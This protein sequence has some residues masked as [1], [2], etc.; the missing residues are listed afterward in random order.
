MRF[1]TLRK[2]RLSDPQIWT[3]EVTNLMANPITKPSLPL[4]T[5]SRKPQAKSCVKKL[6]NNGTKLILLANSKEWEPLVAVT[7]PDSRAKLLTSVTPIS[8]SLSKKWLP[9][10]LLTRSLWPLA[11]EFWANL[12]LE[13]PMMGKQSIFA[14][15][16]DKKLSLNIEFKYFHYFFLRMGSMR[17]KDSLFIMSLFSPTFWTN[18]SCSLSNFY[19]AA[20]RGF[21]TFSKNSSFV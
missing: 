20:S 10:S 4:N 5:T 6:W 16:K 14:N 17:F 1:R 21:F 11:W 18:F 9:W 7:L 19:R 13:P 8:R 3:K 2:W 12:S 15:I